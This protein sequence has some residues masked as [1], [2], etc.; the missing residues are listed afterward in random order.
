MLSLLFEADNLNNSFLIPLQAWL[1]L[2]LNKT[3]VYFINIY[4]VPGSMLLTEWPRAESLARGP[5]TVCTNH[6]IFQNTLTI[7]ITSNLFLPPPP[8][9]QLIFMVVTL[10][11]FIILTQPIFMIYIHIIST[12]VIFKKTASSPLSEGKA[13]LR[14]INGIKNHKKLYTAS[15]TGKYQTS[16]RWS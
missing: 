3:T 7:L 4:W 12:D 14:A 11:P 10:L 9:G 16:Q 5:E 8:P 2:R 6:C 13:C 1:Y 15:H